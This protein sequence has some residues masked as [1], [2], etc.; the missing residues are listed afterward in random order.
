M[1]HCLRTNIYV[2]A[3]T[4]ANLLQAEIRDIEQLVTVGHEL[5]ACP[6]YG[7][8][9]AIPS[10]QLVVLPYNTLLHAPTRA[11]VGVQLRGN[12]VVIDEAHNLLD[13]ISSVYSVEITG[14]HVSTW[15]FP[16]I[17]MS[18]FL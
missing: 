16:Y 18:A 3:K 8:R 13:A 15:M 14:S 10:A 1:I 7:V 11:A 9:Y 5:K 2:T 6:Y 4:D 12:V 17:S